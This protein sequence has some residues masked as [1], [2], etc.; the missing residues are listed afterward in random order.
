MP[1][2]DDIRLVCGNC[3]SIRARNLEGA[4]RQV[5]T[6]VSSHMPPEIMLLRDRFEID[7]NFLEAR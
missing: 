2:R 1:P 7:E 5:E 3:V 6:K 4:I